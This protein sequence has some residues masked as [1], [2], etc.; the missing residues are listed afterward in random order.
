MDLRFSNRFTNELPADPSELNRPREV[1]NAA[2]SR[3]SPTQ[4]ASPQLLA[5]SG[6]VA[7]M[8]GLENDAQSEDF[9]NAMSGNLVT[10]EMDPY[11]ACYGGHQFGNWAGQLGDG[12]AIALGEVET[13]SDGHLTLQ[14]K[15]SG[16]T[17]YSRG[18][19]GRAVLRSSVREFL[20]SEAMFH[21]GVPTTRALSL[22]LTGDAVVRDVLHDG[23]PAPEPGAV[24][25]R[26]A[27]SFVRFG[28]FELPSSRGEFAELRQLADFT[29]RTEFPELLTS[30]ESGPEPTKISAA[31][32]LAWFREVA[33]RTAD[34]VVHWMRVG[35]VHGVLNTDNL[36][37]TGLTI[38]YGPYG[39]QDNYD[40]TWTPNTTDAAQRRYRFGSQARIAQWNL[41][42]LGNALYPLIAHDATINDADAAG[43]Q[44]A[45]KATI[46]Q[47]QNTL[48]DFS[49]SYDIAH[50]QMMVAKLG[51]SPTVGVVSDEELDAMITGAVQVLMMVETDMTIFY[52]RL[53]DIPASCV[54]ETDQQ[55]SDR[56][57]EALYIPSERDE[58]DVAMTA[59]W[60]RGY[61][62][63]ATANGIDD[64]HRRSAMNE[65]NPKYVPRNYLAQL[66][67]EDA[68]SGDYTKLLELQDAL[69]QPYSEQ[70]EYEHLAAKRPDWAR[71]K[72]GCSQ[73]SCSS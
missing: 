51:L 67:I 63:L 30:E 60:L 44:E 49:S 36:S 55:L 3:V 65:V 29:I 45:D 56:L 14:L 48:D 59:A 37:I 31:T 20:C 25:C 26:V 71:T 21:L 4:T 46:E 58:N 7:A 33:K 1:R 43:L 16:R 34:L 73:L 64:A 17:P 38:D 41:A 11:A 27:S 70:P 62:E 52:R 23:H 28:S 24:V 53:A 2:F 66:A 19:D 42:Q 22:A 50:R 39:W 57:L 5:V 12:R 61:L 35:F 47:L 18:A 10:P 69:R 40:P 8:L 54:S 32:Y 13:E 6:D 72:V 15:G 68:E 9:L